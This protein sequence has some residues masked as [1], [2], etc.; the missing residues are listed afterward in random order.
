MAKRSHNRDDSVSNVVVGIMVGII[1]MLCAILAYSNWPRI[2]GW[3][4]LA[5]ETQTPVSGTPISSTTTPVT[6]T[7]EPSNGLFVGKELGL[8][9]TLRKGGD[10]TSYSHTL[11]TEQYGTLGLKSTSVS[12][13]EFKGTVVVGGIVDDYIN[14]VYII[15]VNTLVPVADESND[16]DDT[17]G[18]STILTGVQYVADGAIALADMKEAGFIAFVDKSA[19]E[20]RIAQSGDLEKEVTLEYFLCNPAKNS[21]NCTATRNNLIGASRVDYTDSYG[22]EFYI[23]PDSNSWFGTI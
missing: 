2:A 13:N 7:P 1:I 23:L 12:L 15:R 19:Q 20:I 6:E 11:E 8:S 5:E 4:G 10:L 3:I 17:S 16:K 14:G 22:Y 21:T 9:G 18:D